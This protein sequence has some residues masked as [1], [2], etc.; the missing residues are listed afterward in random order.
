MKQ[1][2]L[3]SK[4]YPVQISHFPGWTRY[5]Y[6]NLIDKMA[7]IK[8]GGL[9]ENLQII[10]CVDDDSVAYGKSPLINQLNKNGIPFINA[11]E[12][13]DVYP[14]VNNK[15]IQLLYDAL[16]N[17]TSEYCLILDGI[18]VAIN[19][20]L[21]DIINI[22]KTYN[23]KIIY[24]ATPWMH[25]KVVID[26][27][28]NRKELYGKYCFLNAGCCI[29]ETKALQDFY[30][31]ILEFFNNTPKDDQFWA[32]EQYYV[33]RVFSNHMD[34]VFFDYDCKLFQVWH[35]T[36][37]NLPQIDSKTGN[38]IYQIN[39]EIEQSNNDDKKPKIELS[40]DD[41]NSAMKLAED[42]VKN[43]NKHT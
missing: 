4:G 35:R 23:K 27:I 15:K 9:P 2:Y 25:P 41:L 12:H 11:A 5:K 43:N 14:W 28:D 39:D 38:I 29:G 21:S 13:K 26:V 20:D 10:T 37:V 8:I 6:K 42:I 22:Y 36:E 31:E 33:R 32:S 40:Q 34:T 7:S 24:N 19:D 18:D 3:T 30:N 16:Q 1:V 17:V